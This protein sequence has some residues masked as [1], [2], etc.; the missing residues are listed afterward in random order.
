[1]N[2]ENL[3]D[4]F[5]HASR[6]CVTFSTERGF[7]LAAALTCAVISPFSTT[8]ALI[9]ATVPATYFGIGLGLGALGKGIG[10]MV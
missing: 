5:N 1:M 6:E 7:L 9:V 8:L 10:L 3:R 2:L 4:K